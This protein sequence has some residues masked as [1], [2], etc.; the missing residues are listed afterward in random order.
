M[1]ETYRSG[2]PQIA[3]YDSFE[4]LALTNYRYDYIII[5]DMDISMHL[6]HNTQFYPYSLKICKQILLF[7]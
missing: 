4:W 7:T 5:T 1:V 3:G 6:S 2:L